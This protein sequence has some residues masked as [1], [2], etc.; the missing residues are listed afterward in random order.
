[1]VGHAFNPSISKAETEGFWWVQSQPGLQSK[2]Q[3]SEGYI[4]KG[5]HSKILSQMLK[6]YNHPLLCSQLLNCLT[7]QPNY[8]SLTSVE[9]MRFWPN[10]TVGLEV[11]GFQSKPFLP[12]SSG[13]AISCKL[14]AMLRL[15][16]L[17]GRIKWQ[18]GC[19][20][21]EFTHLKVFP[22]C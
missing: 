1:M 19:R 4:V 12:R 10:R 9:E 17:P 3:A 5:L 13:T 14:I 8:R 22:G 18:L 11:H 7:S 6:R 20:F 2:V 16:L 15:L 21:G